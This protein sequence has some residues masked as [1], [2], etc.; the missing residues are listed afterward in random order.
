M[1]S[2]CNPP[3]TLVAQL[4]HQH[5]LC[6]CWPGCTHVL[7]HKSLLLCYGCDGVCRLGGIPASA[8][9]FKRALQKGSVGL[10]PGARNIRLKLR[11]QTLLLLAAWLSSVG[12]GI[13]FTCLV[14]SQMLC[15]HHPGPCLS[16]GVSFDMLIVIKP[17]CKVLPCFSW[18]LILQA[19]PVGL[20]VALLRCS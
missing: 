19:L 3:R 20:Q 13:R 8:S 10:V 18:P 5:V 4:T 1:G 15:D 16:A 12:H 14:T 7:T 9:S 2:C 17:E 6:S 11:Q